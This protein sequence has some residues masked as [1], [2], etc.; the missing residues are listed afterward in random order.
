MKAIDFFIPN[1]DDLGA[2]M[3]AINVANSLVNYFNIRFVVFNDK[4]KFRNLLDN[5]IEVIQL[6]KGYLNINKIRIFNR[7][8]QYLKY[9][10][11]EKTNIVVSFSPITNVIALFT[12]FFN[13]KLKVVI[14]EHC[15]PS[16]ATEDRQNLS[17]FWAFMFKKVFY[18]FYNKSDLFITISEAIKIDFVNNFKINK[19]II[20]IV[21][22]PVNIDNIIFSTKEEVNDFNFESQKKYLIGV[23]RLVDQKNFTKLLDIFSLIR[24]KRSDVDLIILGH[25]PN[26]DSLIKKSID[27]NLKDSVHFLGFK[28]NPYKFL[29]RANCFCL[30]SL[31]EGL[32]QVIAE[33]MICRV[34]VISVDCE[35]GPKEMIIN[36]ETGILVDK[37][38]NTLF[39]DYICELI[40]NNK[41]REELI[42]KSYNFATREYSIERCLNKYLEILNSI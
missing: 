42:N 41:M 34:P 6:D 31:W 12:K 2:Q 37:D 28:S 10:K 4:G 14:Q 36:K 27:L 11:I 25:G 40:D 32:P 21:R 39:A 16:V 35:S 3:V 33:A 9:S 15:F 22:N 7:L 23:G 26:L 1:F 13:S 24:Q 30:T 19:D 17:W 38:D 18:K 20:K 29:S 5:K 8:F